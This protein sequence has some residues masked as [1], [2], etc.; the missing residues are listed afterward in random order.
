[1][2][3]RAPTHAHGEINPMSAAIDLPSPCVS[4]CELDPVTRFCRGCLRTTAEIAAWRG[5]EDP[6]VRRRAEILLAELDLGW[7]KAVR[8]HSD[9]DVRKALLQHPPSSHG[10]MDPKVLETLLDAATAGPLADLRAAAVR[11]L[12]ARLDSAS[13]GRLARCL[14]D[15]DGTV[16]L[17]AIRV[18]RMA[19][20]LEPG[21]VRSLRS[22]AWGVGVNDQTQR[23]ARRTLLRF[24]NLLSPEELEGLREEAV[25]R[26]PS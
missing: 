25:A 15:L 6:K 7:E 16:V 13:T 8:Y 18:L 3:F 12:P 19:R 21:A 20:T 11:G 10:K 4:V 2:H 23:E 9:L 1:M 14:E 17:G 5:H 22:L 26:K 24:P